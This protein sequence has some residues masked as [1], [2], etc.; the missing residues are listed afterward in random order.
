[1]S[2]E[3]ELTFKKVERA[4]VV[5]RM[6]NPSV[7]GSRKAAEITYGNADPKQ[8]PKGDVTYVNTWEL[9]SVS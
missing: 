9:E 4:V 6:E 2:H 5:V 7:A 1:M 8:F 3:V